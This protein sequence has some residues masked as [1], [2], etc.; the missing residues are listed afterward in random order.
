MSAEDFRKELEKIKYHVRLL[1]ET[2]NF[3]DHPIEAL[4]LSKDWNEGDIER[5]HDIF[6]KYDKLLE[7]K[8]PVSWGD[9][10][11]ELED[12]FNTGYQG[13]KPIIVAFFRN[14][15]W[16]NVCHG[17]AMSFEPTTPIEFHEITRQ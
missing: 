4:I 6:E 11:Q 16:T 7:S 3:K 2:I 13:V 9:F 14:G 15:Q 5:A 1:G 8:Q 12:T 10:E 17:Y